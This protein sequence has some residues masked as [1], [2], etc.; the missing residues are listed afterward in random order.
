M[1]ESQRGKRIHNGILSDPSH[2]SDRCRWDFEEESP[3]I[4]YIQSSL[5][6]YVYMSERL[7]RRRTDDIPG[8]GID[9]DENRI[10]FIIKAKPLFG[11]SPFYRNFREKSR[12]HK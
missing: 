9:W 4:V 12:A 8:F 1:S 5:R 10:L 7:S 6:T 3:C 11:F 2:D